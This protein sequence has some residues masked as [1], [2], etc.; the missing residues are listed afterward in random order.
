M[1]NEEIIAEF[2][3]RFFN[4]SIPSPFELRI[5]I[6]KALE[7]KDREKDEAVKKETER[8]AEITANTRVSRCNK[9][10]YLVLQDVEIAIRNPKSDE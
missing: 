5:F 6:K 1:Q 9:D 7:A 3:K 8:C 4:P 2:D 10:S